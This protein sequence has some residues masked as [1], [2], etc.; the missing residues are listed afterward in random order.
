MIDTS[1]CR[2][3]NYTSC[4]RVEEDNEHVQTRSLRSHEMILQEK[5]FRPLD[6][7]TDQLED[8]VTGTLSELPISGFKAVG[9]QSEEVVVVLLRSWR[10]G[11]A[12][13]GFWET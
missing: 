6:R 11:G 3:N 7:C 10:G 5:R 12:V 2:L 4:H 13:G 8:P 9:L 1:F